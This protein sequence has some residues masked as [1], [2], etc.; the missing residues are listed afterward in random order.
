MT[1]GATAALMDTVVMPSTPT[2][3]PGFI[4]AGC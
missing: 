2:D 4:I 1:A 3:V